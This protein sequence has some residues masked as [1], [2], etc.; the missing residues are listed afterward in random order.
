[1]IRRYHKHTLQT[2]PRF[3]E[4]EPQKNNNNMTQGRQSKATSSSFPIK[5]I[6]KLEKI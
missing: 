4:E 3:R 6:A 1:M 5:M 2:N